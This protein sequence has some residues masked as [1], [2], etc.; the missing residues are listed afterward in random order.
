MKNR[1]RSVLLQ[2]RLLLAGATSVPA[3]S[4]VEVECSQETIKYYAST[5]I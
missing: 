1:P 4:T 3:A 5:I 2:T